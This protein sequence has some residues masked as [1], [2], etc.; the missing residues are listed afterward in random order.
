MLKAILVLTCIAA[1]VPA[2]AAA[3]EAE[4]SPA[5]AGSDTCSACHP[6]KYDAW[7]T[8]GHSGKKNGADAPATAA[9]PSRDWIENCSGCHTTGESAEEAGRGEMGVGCEACHGPGGGHVSNMGHPGMIASS[10]AADIC[11]RCH[12]GN[13]S[14]TGLLADG[15]RWV[16]GFRPGMRLSDVPGL[17]MT[18]LDPAEP[19]PAPLDGHPLTYN[20][21]RASGHAE[22]SDKTFTIGGRE[23]TGQIPCVACHDPHQ[24]EHPHQL[25]MD[26]H[27]IC[28][29]CHRVQQEV[30]T[31]KGA[32]GIEETRSLHTAISCVECHMTEKN[33]LMRVLR[34]DDPKLA[35]ERTDTCSACHE[36]KD[37]AVRAHQIQDWEA[38]YR[39]TMEPVEAAVQAVTDALKK[40][41]DALNAEL[42]QKLADTK[43]NLAVIGQ[44]GSRGVHNLDYALEIMA[45]AKRDLAKIKAALE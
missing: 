21:W 1:T 29:A 30:V 23:W 39:E 22:P 2:V 3:D 43:A 16:A 15:T 32:K 11:G 13:L 5:Y 33:H 28:D 12:G 41:P 38:W 4:E 19:P 42:A 24:S 31:G 9:E 20:M 36:M 10:R 35:P 26:P 37:R 44:D 34:P 45:L 27:E 17:Q 6:D 40:N 18:S 7:K 8:S 25:V 14:G